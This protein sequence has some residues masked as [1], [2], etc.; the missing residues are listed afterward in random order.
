MGESDE[1]HRTAFGRNQNRRTVKDRP[2]GAHPGTEQRAVGGCLMLG[3]VSGMF[4][5]L[6]LRQAANGQHTQHQH[7]GDEFTDW[8]VHR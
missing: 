1:R 5:R 7:N 2:R 6:R 3:M 4:R 8:V